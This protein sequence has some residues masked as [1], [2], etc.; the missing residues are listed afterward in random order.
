M[1]RPAHLVGHRT[2]AARHRVA[3]VFGALALLWGLV[4]VEP[5]VAQTAGPSVTVN[6]T[7]DLGDLSSADLACNTG[8]L[9]GGAAECTLRA[10]IE[11]ANANPDSTAI[12]FALPTGDAGYAAGVWVIQPQSALP[13]MTSPTAIDA[14]TQATWSGMGS[15]PAPVVVLDGSVLTDLGQPGIFIAAGGADSSI[16]GLAIV[17]HP[18]HAIQTNAADNTITN[19]YVGLW[20]D[21]TPDGNAGNGV[22]IRGTNALVH[23]NVIAS[24][25]NDG[26]TLDSVLDGTVITANLIGLD[27]NGVPHGNIQ[28]IWTQATGP[29]SI[30]GINPGDGNVIANNTYN[31]IQVAAGQQTSIT[32]NTI[33]NN[34]FPGILLDSGSTLTVNDPGD[35]DTG[36]NG[37]L[38]Y[39]IISDSGVAEEVSF[40]LD[41]PAGSYRVEFFTN[42]SG[43]DPSGRGEGELFVGFI[44][45]PH[46]GGAV[47]YS[48]TD[49]ALVQGTW[50]SATSTL[51]IAG[52]PDA[53]SEFSPTFQM[54]G[55]RQIVVNSTATDDDLE[56]A[57]G[58]ECRTGNFLPDATPEC[59]LRA[60]ITLANQ[61]TYRD[62]ISFSFPVA[63]PGHSGGVWTIQ[64]A[65]ALPTASESLVIDGSTQPGYVSTL[66]VELDGQG[67][68]DAGLLL[69]GNDSVVRGLAIG[70][71]GDGIRINGSTG[72]KIF[73]NHIGL[74]AS[75]S[76]ARPNL[77]DGIDLTSGSTN[78]EVGGPGV[79]E[80]NLVANNGDDGISV[81]CSAVGGILIRSNIVGTDLTQSA[82]MGNGDS[83]VSI[84]GS[85]QVTVGG[86]SSAEGNVLLNSVGAGIAVADPGADVTIRA[87]QIG[88]NSS[89]QAHPNGLGVVVSGAVA[90][91]QIGGIPTPAANVIA[92]NTGS[93]V[94]VSSTSTEVLVASNSIHSNGFGIELAPDSPNDPGDL[95][96][97]ANHQLN[98]PVL[99][100]VVNSGAGTFQYLA[101]LDVP[102]DQYRL[103]LFDNTPGE[104][105]GRTFLAASTLDTTG[106]TSL[107]VRSVPGD[108]TG[109]LTGTL[110]PC[111]A[112]CT[113]LRT[114]TSPFSAAVAPTSASVSVN[115]TGDLPDNNIGDGQCDTGA[116][117]S[118]GVPE[119]TLRAAI[120]ELNSAS[121][122]DTIN[123]NIG[124]SDPGHNSGTWTI[125]PAT[126]LPYISGTGVLDARTQPGYVDTP[127]IELDGSVVP[128]STAGLYVEGT[129]SAVRGFMVHSFSDDGIE[130]N[131]TAGAGVGNF[132]TDNWVG[133]NRSLVPTPNVDIGILIVAGA[134]DNTLERNVVVSSNSAAIEI[135]NTGSDNN[136]LINNWVGELPDGTAMPNSM[137]GVR[138]FDLA[139]GTAIGELGGGNVIS[140][141][142]TMGV[143]VEAT[144]GT[145]TA[146]IDNRIEDNVA[147]GV[148][149][150]A[151][152][153]ATVG[154]NIIQRNGSHGL[155]LDGTTNSQVGDPAGTMSNTISGN[156]LDGIFI[157]G[158]PSD[159]SIVGNTIG[160]S[161]FGFPLPNGNGINVTGTVSN[162]NIGD[163]ATEVG[164]VIANNVLA[165]I[166]VDDFTQN[167]FIAANEIHSNGIGIELSPDSPND[168]GDG[169]T[170]ANHQL[171]RPVLSGVSNG[172]TD[173][174]YTVALDVPVS[175]YRLDLFENN[176]GENQGRTFL[177]SE[178]VDKNNALPMIFFLSS[179]GQASGALTATLTPCDST[180]TNP[181]LGTSPFSA[182]VPVSTPTIFVN[183][184][185]NAADNN[186]GDDLCD[187]GA[188]N[189]QGQPECTLA[190]AIRE[191]NVSALVNAISF[192]IPVSD[193][194]HSGGVWTITP[195][196]SLT[197]ITDQL[198]VDARTQPGYV[199]SPLIE[200][201][202]Q[203]STD[204]DGLKI[205]AAATNTELYGFAVINYSDAGIWSRADDSIIAYNYSGLR[206]DGLTPAPNVRGI[207]IWD[208]GQRISIHSNVVSGNTASGIGIFDVGSNNNSIDGNFVG[209]GASGLVAVPNGGAGIVISSGVANTVGSTQPNIVS[210]NLG[211]GIRNSS[212]GSTVIENNL[213]GLTADGSA[214]LGNGGDGVMVDGT[215]SFVNIGTSGAGN[216]IGGSGG[217]GIRI[218][219]A[220]DTNTIR[221]NFIGTNAARSLSLGN[222]LNGIL[223][224]PGSRAVAITNNEL[225]NNGLDGI[226]IDAGVT[227][228]IGT[229]RNETFN[230][231]GLGLDLG[232]DG[233]TLND[234]GDGD[235]GPNSLLNYPV[236]ESIDPVGANFAITYVLDAPAANYVVDFYVNPAGADPS[237][238]GEAEQWVVSH[239]VFSHP[240][241]SASYTT[242]AIPL[243]AGALI[244]GAAYLNGGGN[245]GS[246]YGP[247]FVFSGTSVVNSTGDLPDSTIGDGICS[248]G[249][250]VSTGDA[251][252]TLRAAIQE[253]NSPA[254]G[255]DVDFSILP[256]DGLYNITGN[257]EF[258]VQPTTPLPAITQSI[259]IDGK[260]QPGYVGQPLIEIDGSLSS[261]SFS[262]CSGLRI[263]GGTA[264]ISGLAINSWAMDGI[265]IVTPAVAVLTNNYLGTDVT[266]AAAEPNIGAGVRVSAG[267]I[268][269]GDLL[270]NNIAFNGG[271]GVAIQGTGSE[272]VSVTYNSIHSNVGLGIDLGD[273]GPT[274]NDP[275]DVDSGAN[276][277]LNTPVITAITDLGSGQLQVEYFF[278]VPAGNYMLQAFANPL[279]PNANG[280]MQGEQLRSS[281]PITSTG[282]GRTELALTISG[283][284]G[285]RITM[286]ITEDLAPL[287]WGATSEFSSEVTAIPGQPQAV[288]DSGVDRNDG[289]FGSGFGIGAGTVGVI[290]DAFDFA[291]S[292]D[293]VLLPA[294]NSTSGELTLSA[295][296]NPATTTNATIFSSA[297]PSGDVFSLGTLDMGAD[298]SAT[299]TLTLGGSPVTVSG[300]TLSVGSWHH[301]AITWD[302][303]SL[304]LFV[305]GVAVDSV[306]TAG[307]LA[308]HS[309]NTSS[310]GATASGSGS[311]IGKIDEVR[312]QPVAMNA[313]WVLA[314]YYFVTQSA[315]TGTLGP[316]ETV[317]AMPWA[318]TGIGGRTGPGAA[319]APTGSSGQ[320][321]LVAD[322]IDEVGVEF[323]SWWYLT[324][325]SGI[326][327]GQGARTSALGGAQNEVRV[328][329][330]LG[331]EVSEFG[332]GGSNQRQAA[333]GPPYG[334]GWRRI[335]IRI[336]QT[337]ASIVAVD[338]VDLP[339]PVLFDND[340]AS[341]SVG[342]RSIAL[343]N[344]EQWLVD[345]VVARRFVN[346]E[347][348]TS[349]STY[350]R[351]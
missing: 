38:N 77:D 238:F 119:C 138:V 331:F 140:N 23:Q 202:G 219:A 328:V 192:D 49:P 347:P 326:D 76:Q 26:V 195:T 234:P 59:T 161:D 246:E 340:P 51:M 69:Q 18:T 222:T 91:V 346:P 243:P 300:G 84:T 298:G 80:P 13:N 337:G 95:D 345:D 151:V 64:V 200:I 277:L 8:G 292:T 19:S 104:S 75:G 153:G 62:E 127:V 209:T 94:Q 58:G 268:G 27:P 61:S 174:S 60:A 245:A 218:N 258:T 220:T 156:T 162:I 169:D 32:G 28:G 289:Y 196:S 327:V 53:T 235:A 307:N 217:N 37:R 270:G 221:N 36:P 152:S 102:P 276:Q 146:V 168:S 311:F 4:A 305:D 54:N 165:G 150:E 317:G 320:S 215:S 194:G 88:L 199:A 115:S 228:D 116:T 157:S 97:G 285:E 291:S 3:G 296:V 253:A 117:T 176:L 25:G 263:Q 316:Q 224:E 39:P 122:I 136:K 180:C 112:P 229:I 225:G 147:A 135:R 24:N 262:D 350:E 110:T 242:P 47:S 333:S 171:N 184:T 71:F 12:K 141:S 44:T 43:P 50:V 322:G 142:G 190:A 336:D 230:N 21:L 65:S 201:D 197:P 188:L 303:T 78:I 123:F 163:P 159:L 155:I 256:A 338:G 236:V 179:P 177:A 111:D 241:G 99:S 132:V 73:G 233:P 56:P 100:N 213:I 90:K 297:G 341:G 101:D 178:V 319:N 348:V 33:Y 181:Q 232:G 301:V 286:N 30:G 7:G 302:S 266:G 173:F 145:G 124:V 323:E 34:G 20:P 10:A 271:A 321:W 214:V 237:G 175:V 191:A 106:G 187:T 299:A 274:P 93:A 211:H 29:I 267:T 120:E 185:G 304:V 68:S 148:D 166:R 113:A 11:F 183:S 182:P 125:Q 189:S 335:R 107:F 283:S 139:V 35:V 105:Q 295:W 172:A 231:G 290:G 309:S 74:D 164:N 2:L 265:E 259:S 86:S 66:V 9:V 252:C 278:D 275:G 134:A 310:I 282:S 114:G 83:A 67:I 343:P 293:R 273:D 312:V 249:A 48:Y 306:S 98:R 186:A 70:G 288:L 130:I 324:T 239:V 226:R 240:G 128:S 342:F 144:A 15:Y 212:A 72:T 89:A 6:S 16:A 314:D 330:S 210:G 248:T 284:V 272:A 193:P 207:D 257:G 5:V 131:G 318:Q 129:G 227:F 167:V 280:D 325:D 126:E 264:D 279:G 247:V 287:G 315:I 349:V 208:G 85:A 81:C 255:E 344:G 260:T 121:V 92:H 204:N 160:V 351:R 118:P 63:D 108:V 203:I 261:C 334:S 143:S 55:S 158:S 205:E 1:N 57:N 14:T 40:E 149:M 46:G 339:G 313:D 42:P 198:I 294:L 329:S 332:P 17:A 103:E 206:A 109:V 308:V 52:A 22:F 96:T 82:I 79:G 137:Q 281:V 216:T 133:I 41:G 154:A 87:N 31:G 254:G 170:G 244:T 223:I 269:G 251:E 250:T 45:I